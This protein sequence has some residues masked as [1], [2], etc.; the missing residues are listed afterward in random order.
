[1][2]G[3]VKW[4]WWDSVEKVAGVGWGKG[5]ITAKARLNKGTML[6]NGFAPPSLRETGAKELARARVTDIDGFNASMDAEG[7]AFGRLFANVTRAGA[8][9]MNTVA[10][11]APAHG[12]AACRGTVS[13]SWY[14]SG[15]AVSV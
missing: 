9:T 8:V 7:G 15:D 10:P 14:I 11:L 4:E 3:R 13:P 12:R 2:I 6:S 5:S 1:M